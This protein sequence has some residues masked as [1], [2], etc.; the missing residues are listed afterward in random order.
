MKFVSAPIVIET[1]SPNRR[2]TTD[3]HSAA[4]PQPK[5]VSR[6]GAKT[7]K[8]RKENKWN[9]VRK[10]RSHAFATQMDT[11]EGSVHTGLSWAAMR[12]LFRICVHLCPSVAR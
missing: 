7:A 3:A 4:M 9:L 8:S 11:D 12:F 1:A 5:E 6:K 2:L 10:T